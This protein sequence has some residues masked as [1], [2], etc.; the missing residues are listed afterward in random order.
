M[1]A[2]SNI[3]VRNRLADVQ[4]DYDPKDALLCDAA[5]QL[6]RMVGVTINKD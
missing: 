2:L 5:Q 4:L 1:L 6:E 3:A